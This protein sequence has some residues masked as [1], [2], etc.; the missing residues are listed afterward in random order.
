MRVYQL[1]GGEMMNKKFK[2]G[3]VILVILVVGSVTVYAAGTT[4]GSIDDPVVTKSYVDEQINKLVKSG[5]VGTGGA[6]ELIVEELKT[7]DILLAS[8]GTEVILRGGYAVAYGD[9]TNGIPDVTGGSD[10][11]IG[12]NIPKNHQLIFPRDD[13]RGIKITKGIAYVMIRGGYTITK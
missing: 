10:L 4:P 7:G 2:L 12:S 6:V 8:A 5:G 3:L 1:M 9:G 11:A 13:G